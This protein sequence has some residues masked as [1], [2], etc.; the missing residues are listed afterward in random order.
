MASTMLSSAP[1][2]HCKVLAKAP[3]AQQ[4][5]TLVEAQ[6]PAP[7]TCRRSSQ[8]PPRRLLQKGTTLA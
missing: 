4:K 5:P 1:A 7:Q 2:P 8:D 6:G 3:Q